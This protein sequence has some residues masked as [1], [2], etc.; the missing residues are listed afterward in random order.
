VEAACF[1][2]ND[3]NRWY[4]AIS[5]RLLE[6]ALA[7]SCQLLVAGSYSG[8]LIPDEHYIPLSADCSNAE[9]VFEKM[10]DVDANRARI[11]ACYRTFVENPKFHYRS[12]VLG[13][14]TRIKTI[15]DSKGLKNAGTLYEIEASP[16]GEAA[17][18]DAFTLAVVRAHQHHIDDMKEVG[19]VSNFFHTLS[20]AVTRLLLSL[21]SR[22]RR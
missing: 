18:R 2:S 9:Q 11:D 10:R 12:F 19:F 20:V 5:P 22:F 16:M 14:L 17:L 4:S 15:A 6:A 3:M 7:R 8:A 1:P 13:M 21:A